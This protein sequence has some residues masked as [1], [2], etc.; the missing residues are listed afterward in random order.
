[1]SLLKSLEIHEKQFL[2]SRLFV[3]CWAFYY[4]RKSGIWGLV[5]NRAATKVFDV[6]PFKFLPLL[7]FVAVVAS[8]P[9]GTRNESFR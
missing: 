4:D 3:R 8:S 9:K 1:M 7:S 6:T 2:A 5:F